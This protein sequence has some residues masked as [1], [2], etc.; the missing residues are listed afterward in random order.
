MIRSFVLAAALLALG[1]PAWAQAIVI[2]TDK[3]ASEINN[4]VSWADIPD[5]IFD[6]EGDVEITV[7][8]A[9]QKIWVSGSTEG[10]KLTGSS[11]RYEF[12]PDRFG[13]MVVAVGIDVINGPGW[14]MSSVNGASFCGSP[15]AAECPSA[16][17]SSPR[18]GGSEQRQKKTYL[19][20]F[21][22]LHISPQ[23]PQ[24]H[25]LMPKRCTIVQLSRPW[26]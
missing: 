24:S 13:N 22:S 18:P 26:T 3:P 23:M 12:K 11:A 15:M 9:S 14:E 16:Y 17:R 21:K 25:G 19:H 6:C 8:H 4:R 5:L 7:S 1:R 2:E 10:R 20:T